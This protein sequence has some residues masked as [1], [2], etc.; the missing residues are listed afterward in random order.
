MTRII[1]MALA[2][3]L[4]QI[5]LGESTPVLAEDDDAP[6]KIRLYPSAEPKPALKYKLLPNRIDQIAGNAAVYYGKVKCENASFFSSRKLWDNIHRWQ[7]AP[8]ENLV[9]EKA[10]VPSGGLIDFHLDRGAR[11]RFCNWQMPIGDVQFYATQLPEVQQTRQYSR[12]MAASARIDIANKRYDQALHRFQTNYALGRNVAEGEFIV[13]GLIGATLCRIMNPQIMEFVQQPDTPNLYWALATLPNP[14]IDFSKAVELEAYGLVLSYP[15]LGNHKGIGLRSY[16]SAEQTNPQLWKVPPS[17]RTAEEWKKL[18]HAV[19]TNIYSLDTAPGSKP[20]KSEE[21]LER[22]CHK[23]FPLVKKSL[24][25]RGMDVEELESMSMHQGALLYMLQLYRDQVD[26]MTKYYCLPYPEAIKG[27]DAVTEHYQKI[28]VNVPEELWVA[29]HLRLGIKFAKVTQTVLE[30]DIAVL[31]IFEALRIYGASHVGKLPK[32]LN[33]ITEVPI[34]LDPVTG[35]SF[36][37]R[38]EGATAFLQ[39]PTPPG[40]PLQYEITMD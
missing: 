37:Y 10:N 34:P 2:G 25:D 4:L 8:L 15:E 21:E 40:A 19:L 39:G 18:Y 7:E 29:E 12:M 36:E 22:N 30:R 24:R 11:C 13:S 28:T 3:L 5:F 33:D 16:S 32:Q 6:I 1:S 14:L 17:R 35:K 23:A 9:T 26:D 27:F 20:L 38:L 31:R